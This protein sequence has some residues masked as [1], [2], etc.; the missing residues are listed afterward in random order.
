MIYLGINVFNKL[1]NN[2]SI[3][4]QRFFISGKFPTQMHHT[5]RHFN[6]ESEKTVKC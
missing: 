1:V 5:K 4:N 6:S 3:N 2:T